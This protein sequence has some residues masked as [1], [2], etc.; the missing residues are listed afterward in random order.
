MI[1]TIVERQGRR[2]KLLNQGLFLYLSMPGL[3]M[4]SS[5]VV[6]SSGAGDVLILTFL[7][8]SSS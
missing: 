1:K 5:I 8:E 7:P 2:E 6:R 3:V 4:H